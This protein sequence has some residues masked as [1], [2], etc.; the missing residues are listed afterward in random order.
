MTSDPFS[1]ALL[2]VSFLLSLLVAGGLW[3]LAW[4]LPAARRF[5]GLLA[6]G[7]TV[8][9]T[10]SIGWGI[11]NVLGGE[12]QPAWTDL[13]YVARYLLVFAAFWFFPTAAMGRRWLELLVAMAAAALLLWFGFV[14]AAVM[15]GHVTRAGGLGLLLYP[16]LD[17]GM[18]YAVWQRWRAPQGPPRGAMPWLALAALAYGIANWLNSGAMLVSLEARTALPDL[19]WFLST[20]LTAIAALRAWRSQRTA[21]AT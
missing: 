12:G 1:A 13:C 20:V 9:L 19:L 10:A 4:R 18:L 17:M 16:T 7:E 11:Y 5:W 6:A 8:A 14:R 2:G 21:S 15:A 3:W